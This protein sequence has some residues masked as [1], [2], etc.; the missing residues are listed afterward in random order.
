MDCQNNINSVDLGSEMIVSK[1]SW[2]NYIIPSIFIAVFLLAVIFSVVQQRPISEYPEQLSPLNNSDYVVAGT[3]PV[4]QVGEANLGDVSLQ[5][6]NGKML[7]RS[8]IYRP[9]KANILFTFTKKTNLLN[10]IDITGPGMATARTVSY[11]D[12]FDKV[13]AKYGKGFIRS[14]YKKNPQTF[15]AVYGDKNCIVFHV[16]N[17]I[18]KKIVILHET[19]QTN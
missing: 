9:A 1:K 16:E 15:D 3:D 5:F 14:Y 17:N 4:L 10:K 11:N 6:P 8:G 13:V 19:A 7:G 18:V 12:S 2:K